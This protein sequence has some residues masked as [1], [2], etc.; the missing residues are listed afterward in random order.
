M[1]AGPTAD[2]GRIPPTQA[3]IAIKR[4]RLGQ[5]WKKRSLRKGEVYKR[6]ETTGMP[7]E[8]LVEDLS[9]IDEG[10]VGLRERVYG[11]S[12][13]YGAPPSWSDRVKY[14]HLRDL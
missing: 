11:P 1:R 6:H 3:G 8:W 4:S 10:F 9:K 12:E 7:E 5:W 14:V 13:P 2:S